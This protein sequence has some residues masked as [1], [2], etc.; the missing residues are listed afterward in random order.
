M[1]EL[2]EELEK[3]ETFLN[4]KE[5]EEKIKEYLKIKKEVE[6][7]EDLEKKIELLSSIDEIVFLEK[8]I[9]QK[10]NEK[11]FSGKY[12]QCD[13]ILEIMAGA[14]GLDAQDWAALLKG[15]YEKFSRKQG[16]K[17]NVLDINYGKGV[18][19]QGRL[20]IKSC[21]LEIIGK[22]AFGLLKKESGIHRLIR[23]SPFSPQKLR[24]TSFAKIDVLPKIEEKNEE[25]K[26][27]ANDLKIDFLKASGPGG[28]YVNKRMTAVRITHL[29][30]GLKVS[31]QSERSQ[32]QNKK[33]AMEILLSHLLMLKEKEKEKELEKIKGKK[34]IAS[35]GNQI[36]SYIFD[37]YQLVKDHRTR[38]EIKNVEKVLD[39]HLDE[40]IEAEIFYQK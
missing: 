28:Q 22:Y 18:G 19:P 32:I 31:C 33:K 15:M 17:L 13:A 40:L 12:D 30:S 1:I 38:V 7:W 29:P 4:E 21:T 10:R 25:I 20:G 26:I 37:P 5:T 24:H 35:F 11:I 6:E 34:T 8:K 36:R 3:R 16:F 39:G 27:S 9:N 23:I 14:G 2:K